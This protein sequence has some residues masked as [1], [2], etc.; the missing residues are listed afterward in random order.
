M[1]FGAF[2]DNLYYLGIGML[3]IFISIAV[4]VLVTVVLNKAFKPKKDAQKE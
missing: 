4:I 2:V 3:S 1:N